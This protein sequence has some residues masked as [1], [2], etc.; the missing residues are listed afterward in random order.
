MGYGAVI[1][2]ENLENQTFTSKI[3]NLGMRY[4]CQTC[5][6]INR[7]GC[8]KFNCVSCCICKVSILVGDRYLSLAIDCLLVVLTT[9]WSAWLQ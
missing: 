1:S 5:I 9:E 4:R 7:S 2:M 6:D 8:K 3:H